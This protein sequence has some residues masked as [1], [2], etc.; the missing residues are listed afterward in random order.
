MSSR[1]RYRKGRKILA[2]SA[3]I[4]TAG[5]ARMVPLVSKKK[6]RAYVP[7]GDLGDLLGYWAK[8]EPVPVELKLVPDL[9][10]AEE[11]RVV[12]G[13]GDVPT[14]DVKTLLRT[15]LREEGMQFDMS[16]EEGL[17]RLPSGQEVA[18]DTARSYVA[19]RCKVEMDDETRSQLSRMSGKQLQSFLADLRTLLLLSP[20]G[21][22]EEG[23]RI[24]VS[25]VFSRKIYLDGLTKDR[26][27]YT[28][29]EVARAAA[30]FKGVILGRLNIHVKA[31]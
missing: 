13:P 17:V 10:R 11:T 9:E 2:R 23:S 16:N 7:E 4:F 18:L 26:F 5:C 3:G 24:P 1:A 8:G 25:I 20:C 31:D 30:L 6:I 19:V 14:V 15:W 22:M 27:M 21:E 29:F 12:V 28:L